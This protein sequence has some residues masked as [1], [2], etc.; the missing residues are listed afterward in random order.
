MKIETE[1]REDHQIKVIAQFEASAL[2]KYKHQAARKIAQKGKI[3]GFRPGKAPYD[4]IARMY[5]EAT[6]E[7]EAV[8][9]MV[10]DVYPT[11]LA[12]TKINPSGPGSLQDISKKD[13]L[14]FT[15]IVPLEPTVDLVGYRDIRK[16]YSIKPISSK[17]VEEFIQRLRKSYSTAEPVERPVKKGDLVY[18]KVD[19][20]I[21]NPSEDDIFEL[22][23]DSP[24]QIVIG[25]N[26]PEQND[27]PYAGFGDKLLKL[28]ANDEKSFKFTYPSD[29]RYEK[30]R[31]KEVEFH[32]TVES[33]KALHLPEIDDAFAQTLGEFENVEK[34]RE[35]I[36]LQLENRQKAEYEHTYF[37]ELLERIISQANV[38]Y[39]PQML[40]HEMEHVVESVNEDLST[41]HLELD[42]YLKSL[43]KEKSVW[44]EEEIKPIARKHLERSLVMDEI[45]KIEKIQVKNEDLQTEFTSMISEMQ[46]STDIKKLEK[47]L[48]N[49]RVANAFAMQ[50]ATRVLNRQVLN[51]MKDIATGNA[52]VKPELNNDENVDS[53]PKK[54]RK[55]ITKEEVEPAS[56]INVEPEKS[57]KSSNK[58]TETVK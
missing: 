44:L 29:S 58:I 16:E 18:L 49:E 43:S 54:P 32:V 37:D 20:T 1:A 56:D 9:I 41:Q 35:S 26:D 45:A 5:G 34:L 22:L 40:E 52:E 55:K 2:E 3:P 4:V 23:K 12:E 13:P 14:Q 38:K 25:D 46:S 33:V 19:S 21:V 8:E 36:K 17:D 30:L 39:P 15:F 53:K 11:I 47:Q 24:L 42:M 10:E 31:E 50:A 6:I 28:S 27:Y 48:K 57:K 51:R 7:E